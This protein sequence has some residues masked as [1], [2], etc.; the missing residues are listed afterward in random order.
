MQRH[1]RVK[2]PGLSAQLT[3]NIVERFTAMSRFKRSMNMNLGVINKGTH[4][5]KVKQ[6]GVVLLVIIQM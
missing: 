6:A 3:W 4:V 1:V 5:Y 2:S